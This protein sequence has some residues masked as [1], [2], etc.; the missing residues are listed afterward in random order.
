MRRHGRSLR[1]S[2][3]GAAFSFPLHRL[4]PLGGGASRGKPAKLRNRSP[5]Q[6][7]RRSRTESRG[8]GGRRA[9]RRAGGAARKRTAAPAG[10]VRP[11]ATGAG[12]PIPR[13]SGG[14]LRSNKILRFS[15]ASAAEKPARPSFQEGGEQKPPSFFL[16][17]VYDHHDSKR[18][19]W[20]TG[21]DSGGTAAG[22]AAQDPAAEPSATAAY[23]AATP[24]AKST[25]K[26]GSF[27]YPRQHSSVSC[28]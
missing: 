22:T 5:P 27:P 3:A 8:N 26:A 6:A 24:R 14:L 9:D 25:E 10:G 17:D 20:L 18:G 12:L 1:I 7:R 28:F 19:E 23:Y 11:N 4:S 13:G 16:Q 15:A 21:H 2:S